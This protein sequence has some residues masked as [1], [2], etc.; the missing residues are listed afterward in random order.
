MN[1][2][3]FSHKRFW[4]CLALILYLSLSLLSVGLLS[5]QSVL[6]QTT[7]VAVDDFESG[8]LNGGLGWLDAN[9]STSGTVAA[10]NAIRYVGTY[11]MRLTGLAAANSAAWR[12]VNLSGYTGVHLQFWW[13]SDGLDGGEYVRVSINNGTA[14]QVWQAT[15][16][17]TYQYVDIDLSSYAMT[18]SFEIRVSTNANATGE[19]VSFDEL[20]VMGIKTAPTTPGGCSGDPPS[21]PA[22]GWTSV[23]IGGASTGHTGQY[24]NGSIYVCGSGK[25]IWDRADQLRYGYKSYSGDVEIVARI[26]NWNPANEWSKAGLMIRSSTLAG[27][28]HATIM[29]TGNNGL[30]FQWRTNNNGTTSDTGGTAFSVPVWLKLTRQGT[31]VR[32]YYSANGLDWTQLGSSQSPSMGTTF[33]VG[34][35]VSS[36]DNAVRANAT[37]SNVSISSTMTPGVTRWGK[38]DNFE[39]CPLGAS[40]ITVRPKPPGLMECASV[41][42]NSNFENSVYG[43]PAPWTLGE[44]E[45]AAQIRSTYSCDA[46]GNT[47][48]Y[49]A[50]NYSLWFKDDRE[51]YPP[52]PVLNPWAYQDF[53]VPSFVTSTENVAVSINLSLYYVVPPANGTSLPFGSG[54]RT[55]GRAQDWLEALITTVD[56]TPLSD[57][58]LLGQGNDSPRGVFLPGSADLAPYFFDGGMEAVKNYAGQKLRLRLEANNADEQGDSRFYIDQIRCDVCYKVKEPDPEPGKVRKV[59]GLAQVLLPSGVKAK[60]QGIDVWAMQMQTG[61]P[62]SPP[63]YEL[64]FQSTYTIQDSTYGFYN[65]QPGR[66]RIYAEFWY[67]GNLYSASVILDNLTVGEERALPDLLLVG[68]QAK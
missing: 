10:S 68:V 44:Q 14:T 54:G 47:G 13:R 57:R 31:T 36:R 11:S 52:Y 56:G 28:S 6:A 63:L 30:H 3:G 5:P 59:G 34:M 64:D 15:N 9:W 24:A 60:F 4:M 48:G 45:L 62:P 41:L 58:A 33:L 43:D 66:Y 22:A 46:D 7:T 1:M 51:W 29:V 21:N 35:A 37:F 12:R 42:I 40:A 25:Q 16:N 19:Y 39:L 32:A 49:N 8:N 38:F 23:D 26:T 61:E 65:L 50:G 53:I 55:D 67:G 20:V 17:T 2:N 18:S 27:A